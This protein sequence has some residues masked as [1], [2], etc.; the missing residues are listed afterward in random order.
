MKRKKILSRRY[1]SAL[2]KYLKEGPPANL[3]PALG[4][5]R[6]AV[7]IG[8]ETLDMARI[9]EGALSI[10]GTA[11]SNK[12]LA[13]RAEV[14]F[15]EA[16]IPIENTHHEAMKANAQMHE[17]NQTLHRRTADLT[18]SKRSLKKTIAR[19]KT[20]E[21][22]LKKTGGR[23]TKLLEESRGLQEYLRHLTRRILTAQEHKR[24]K[25]S[26]ELQDEIAQTLLGINVRL[27]TLKKEAIANADG[28]RKE[29]ANTQRLVE[30]AGKTIKRFAREIRKRHEP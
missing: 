9:H 13:K 23:S 25:L 22:A 5:G 1:A 2:Q 28:F 26:V 20:V 6:Q 3:R 11:G 30:K 18:V 7:A 14:F 12:G 10:L 27:L 8:L 15:A 4:L 24:R 19:R 21:A 16:V 17:V 29:I